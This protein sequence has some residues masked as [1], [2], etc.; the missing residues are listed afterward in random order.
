MHFSYFDT[1][2]KRIS[3]TEPNSEAQY[4]ALGR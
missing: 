3:E 1:L 2:Q 4:S